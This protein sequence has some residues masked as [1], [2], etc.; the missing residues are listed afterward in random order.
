MSDIEIFFEEYPVF[1]SV[2]M[3]V[4]I[5]VIAG[6]LLIGRSFTSADGDILT[7][8]NWQVMNAKKAYIQELNGLRMD[9]L[10]LT[11]ILNADQPDPIQG[12]IVT[13]AVLSHTNNKEGHSALR[14]ERTALSNAAV[15]VRSWSQGAI[16]YE[17]VLMIVNNT[18]QL[19][20]AAEIK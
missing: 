2:I 1:G 14:E 3:I 4:C 18:I 19:L 13:D 20:L 12:Q 17:D 9:A 15:A 8:Q 11:E 7:P 5:V 6:I 10:A 16:A